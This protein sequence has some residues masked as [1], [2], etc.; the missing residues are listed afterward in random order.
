M[1]LQAFTVS[2]KNT[3]FGSNWVFFGKLY[4]KIIINVFPLLLTSQAVIK[5]CS[6]DI[7]KYVAQSF[8]SPQKFCRTF[9][10]FYYL[11]KIAICSDKFPLPPCLVLCYPSAI[12][13]KNAV[14][15]N[16][17]HNRYHTSIKHPI[18][19]QSIPMVKGC[20]GMVFI[21]YTAFSY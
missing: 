5:L 14:C 3:K 9:I 20:M 13:S 11:L 8:D 12:I 10:P 6:N 17:K 21:W 4:Q 15:A 19:G 18:S 2:T 1:I 7:N 16:I